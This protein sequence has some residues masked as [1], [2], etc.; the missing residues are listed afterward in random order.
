MFAKLLGR[1]LIFRKM[2]EILLALAKRTPD[3]PIYSVKN[4]GAIYMERYWLFN[5]ITG[6]KRKYPW[7]KFSIRI[8]VI[9]EPD[10]DRH[11][12]DHPFNAIT[13]P[14]RNGYMEERIEPQYP[15][16]QNLPVEFMDMDDHERFVVVKRFV[17]PGT[18]IRLGYE[19]FHRITSLPNG[20]AITFFAFG[21]Y[22]G[23]WGFLVDGVKVL[24][25]DYFERFK[26]K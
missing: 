23:Q 22:K 14:L 11:R 20:P 26:G 17:M 13:W 7:I 4:P 19:R 15:D 6:T 1:A 21:D 3:V 8:H 9:H 24:R 16:Y 12:H 18:P 25:A 10:F 5:K 2:P